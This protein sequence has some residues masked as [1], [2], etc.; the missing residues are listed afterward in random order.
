MTAE[1]FLTS[2]PSTSLTSS[3]QIPHVKIR[4]KDTPSILIGCSM[5]RDILAETFSDIRFI[6]DDRSAADSSK[7]LF[8][9]DQAITRLDGSQL[10]HYSFRQTGSELCW[11]SLALLPESSNHFLSSIRSAY[12][13]GFEQ[14]NTDYSLKFSEQLQ[15]PY[16]RALSCIEGG[17]CFLFTANEEPCAL[18]G[19]HS[20][21]LSLLALEEQGYFAKNEEVLQKIAEHAVP[22]EW[23]IRMARNWQYH[24]ER[25]PI[26]SLK[27]T[28]K[29][30]FEQFINA[31]DPL[32]RSELQAQMAAIEEKL[33]PLEL[34][35]KWSNDTEFKKALQAPILEE[36]RMK[37]Q[38]EARLF[39]AKLQLTKSVMAKELGVPE[40]NVVI[41]PQ[42]KFHLDMEMFLGAKNTVYVQD[43]QLA[44]EALSNIHYGSRSF[45]TTVE[46]FLQGSMARAP[47]DRAKNQQ[48]VEL[49]AQIG[50]TMVP[51]PGYFESD[52][53]TSRVNFFNGLKLGTRFITNQAP[54][55][56][57]CLQEAFERTV[58][59][60]D[61]DLHIFFA[62]GRT[63]Q[64]ILKAGAGIH[65]ITREIL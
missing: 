64:E 15:I 17:N 16:E 50:C 30:L 60:I 28:K 62:G 56:F 10:I 51:V 25:E 1:V 13:T 14:S 45:K 47:A 37:Y 59:L 65:C 12:S 46:H 33:K 63:I 57:E 42:K 26:E 38:V 4:S 52:S 35:K 5:M 18:V 55:G 40:K 9:R 21:V 3:S 22:S 19:C 49:L 11:S 39:E 48:T 34:L 44:Q 7:L 8:P 27:R 20:Q 29:S 6:L 53:E 36:D 23:A 2:G 31:K 61:P 54:H 32:L 43:E 24:Q 58:R 41:L